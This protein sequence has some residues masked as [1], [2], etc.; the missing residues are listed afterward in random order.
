MNPPK[1][2]AALVMVASALVL[3]CLPT[4]AQTTPPAATWS[5]YLHSFGQ[6][7]N[8]HE[9]SPVAITSILVADECPSTVALYASAKFDDPTRN[10]VHKTPYG[11]TKSY[12]KSVDIPIVLKHGL[13][14]I[15]WSAPNGYSIAGATNTKSCVVV[16]SGY[17]YN[18]PH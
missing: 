8:A 15:E 4:F 7:A 17:Q 5:P 11:T 1:T 3:T 16:V 14:A 9:S 2:L 13:N 10:I 6:G 12:L 18:A